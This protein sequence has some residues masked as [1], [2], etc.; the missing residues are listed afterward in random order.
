MYSTSTH[1]CRRKAS[2]DNYRRAEHA[3]LQ[4]LAERK[5]MMKQLKRANIQGRGQ[6]A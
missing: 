6:R 5:D 3:K 1:S 2:A 4:A